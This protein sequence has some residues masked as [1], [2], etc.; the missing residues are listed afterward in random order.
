MV[1][2]LEGTVE[3]RAVGI[4]DGAVNGLEEASGEGLGSFC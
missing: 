1:G 4:R 3:E 2:K